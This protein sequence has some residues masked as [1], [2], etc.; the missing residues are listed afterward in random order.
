MASVINAE[1]RNP[2]Y[3][4]GVEL[5]PAITA[6]ATAREALAGA[7]A[8]VLAVPSHALRDCLEAWRALLPDDAVLVSL[9][10]GVELASSLRASQVVA[11][12]TGVDPGDVV[13]VSGPNLAQ[14]CASGLPAATVAASTSVGRC[15]RVQRMCH[16]GAFRVYTNTDQVG[17]ELGG[18]VKNPIALAAGIAD[19]MGYGANTKAMLITRGLAEMTRLGTALGADPLTFAGLAGMGDLMATCTSAQSRNRG[20]GEQLGRGRTLQEVVGEM[21]MVAEGVKSSQAILRLAQAHDVEMPITEQVVRIVHEGA[22]PAT[23]VRRLMGRVPKPEAHGLPSAAG[24]R[25]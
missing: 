14:E 9:I 8:V 15:E 4:D 23:S 11:E 24:A 21:N 7:D 5:P 18:A 17:V 16:A 12:V 3:L 1:R 13:V 19:G 25:A 6:T 2:S 20:V 22:D 10:K